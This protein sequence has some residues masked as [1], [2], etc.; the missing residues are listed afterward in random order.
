MLYAEICPKVRRHITWTTQYYCINIVP[1][2][3]SYCM[4]M[5]VQ[6]DILRGT[7]FTNMHAITVCYYIVIN[8]LCLKHFLYKYCVFIIFKW[9]IG[10]LQ[11]FIFELVQY[12]FYQYFNTRMQIQGYIVRLFS[13]EINR[14][15]LLLYNNANY[16]TIDD[17]LKQTITLTYIW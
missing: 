6:Y 8:I 13:I 5:R 17:K 2:S 7:I 10:L 16:F 15:Y 4:S 11:I 14:K 12:K 1:S 9:N 3:I